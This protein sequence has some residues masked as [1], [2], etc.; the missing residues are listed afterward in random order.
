M[1]EPLHQKHCVPCEGGTNP[2]KTVQIA[3]YAPAVPEW[4]VRE[5]EK[6]ISRTWKLKDF[7]ASLAFI[8][9]VGAIAEAEGHHPDIHLTG[10]RTVTLELSTHAIG[11]L[12]ENDFIL[13]TKIDQLPL[14]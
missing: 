13:A 3:A 9:A 7:A 2:L 11:G 14:A 12:S 6:Q 4:R 10:Y 5:D 8:N 1:T